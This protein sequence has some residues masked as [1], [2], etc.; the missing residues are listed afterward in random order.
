MSSRA[1]QVGAGAFKE[2]D[3][4]AAPRILTGY[5]IEDRGD[6]TSSYDREA[7][8]TGKVKVLGSPTPTSTATDD[9]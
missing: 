9:R 3:V 8:A 1:A 6:W 5:R 2:R 4:K 7:H